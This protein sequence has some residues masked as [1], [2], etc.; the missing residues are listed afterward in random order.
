MTGDVVQRLLQHSV[1]VNGR[2][3]VQSEGYAGLLVAYVNSGLLLYCGNVPVHGAF[4]AGFVEHDGMQRLREAADVVQGRLRDVADFAQ[5]GVQGRAFGNAFF[6][7]SEQRADGGEDLAEFIVE[8]AGDRA[9]H[10][11][12]R[13]DQF[14]GEFAALLRER[15]DAGEELA[16]GADQI[17]AG[18]ENR[19]ERGGEK[20][21]DLALHAVV[22]LRPLGS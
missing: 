21:I 8:F 18:E 11:F 3:T 19:G 17:E 7:A 22:N 15:F 16:I 6:R 2:A 9:Q 4:Q 1:N 13:G 10:G 14:L 5:I 20:S 12:L